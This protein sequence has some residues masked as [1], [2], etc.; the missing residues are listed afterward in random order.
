MA[1][2]TVTGDRK[3]VMP[4]KLR[5]ND[6]SPVSLDAIVDTGFDGY[7]TLPNDVLRMSHAEEASAWLVELGDGRFVKMNS[8]LV[9]VH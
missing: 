7:L 3:I 6:E 2:G 1:Q 4:L 5:G 8:Y 9:E